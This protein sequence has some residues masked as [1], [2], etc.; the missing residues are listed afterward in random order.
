M[1]NWPLLNIVQCGTNGDVFL[2]TIDITRNHK[3][4]IYVAAQI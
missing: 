2:D 3:D 4:H 1:Q